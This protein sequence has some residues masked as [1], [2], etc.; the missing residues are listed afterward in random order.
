MPKRR[1]PPKR[2]KQS[3]LTGFAS[4]S[5][6]ARSSPPKRASPYTRSSA[7]RKPK[8]QPVEDGGDNSDGDSSDVGNIKFE[9]LHPSAASG[10]EASETPSLLPRRK[11]QKIIVAVDSD[12]DSEPIAS[13]KPTRVSGRK[14]TSK[15]D[16]GNSKGKS[17]K[18]QPQRR[19]LIKG[20]NPRISSSEEED[21]EL[22][23]DPVIEARFRTRGKLTTFQKNLER[24][25]RRKKGLPSESSISG[26]E[27]QEESDIKP[28][29]GAKPTNSSD[30]DSLFDSNSDDS[31]KSSDFIVEDDGGAAVLPTQFSMDTHQDMAHQFKKVFQFFVH[32]AV[33]PAAERR[34]FMTQQ[35]KSEEYFS[36]PLQITR[37]K[38]LGLRDSLVTSSVWKPKFKKPL[39]RYPEFELVPLDFAVPS[40]DA[41]NLG[42]RMSTLLGRTYGFPYDPLGFEMID[43]S[44][45]DS[46]GSID[47]KKK[48]EEFH[49]GRFCAKRTRVYHEFTHWEYSL[50]RCIQREVDALHAEKLEDGFFRIAFSG[51]KNPPEDLS[52]AD[53]ICD[54]LD[55]R[56]IIDMEWKK[57]KDMMESARNLE[58]AAKRGR[59]VD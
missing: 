28:F 24:L 20:K 30:H 12:S 23:D 32:I 49:L 52:D 35:M 51:G 54:W 2:L 36:V 29:K 5:S 40:C 3:T 8:A 19:K 42:G 34:D 50:F 4:T 53:G 13:K 9:P 38:I 45:E 18:P 44:D 48:S 11:R 25:K 59:D 46:D 1:A 22:S 31:D 21:I 57:V 33:R 39:D 43:S 10:S 37:R 56:K 41:C 47:P 27:E 55:E 7:T 58:M 26:S 6:P 16:S 14:P 17:I 15:K